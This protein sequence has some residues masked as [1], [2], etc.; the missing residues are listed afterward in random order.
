MALSPWMFASV[1]SAAD[2]SQLSDTH[3][4]PINLI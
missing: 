2:M 4:E 1:G 3:Q